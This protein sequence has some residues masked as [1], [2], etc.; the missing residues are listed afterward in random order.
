MAISERRMKTA[1]KKYNDLMYRL[2][3]DYL[4]IGTSDSEFPEEKAKWN[5]RDMVSEC[6]Y[7]LDMYSEEGTAQWEALHWLDDEKTTF[8]DM[9]NDQ[10]MRD[11]TYR[12]RGVQAAKEEMKALQKFINTYKK[13]ILDVDVHEG[14]CSMWD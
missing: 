13:D 6:Q 10:Y 7:Q 2:C 12:E 4:T 11:F 1:I 14:H 8:E 9:L 5:L 3:L